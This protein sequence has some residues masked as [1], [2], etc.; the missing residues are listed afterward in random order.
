MTVNLKPYLNYK[1]SGIEHLGKVP[2]H[3]D[4]RTLG[5]IGSFLKGN[6]GN[7]DDEVPYGIPCIR[8]GDLYTTHDYFID[9]SRSCISDGKRAE[10]TA[11]EFGDVLFAGSGETIA[12]IGKSCIAG[13]PLGHSRRSLDRRSR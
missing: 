1:P 10:Y 5:Q 8:Y 13:R 2:A 11:I 3:W 6:G 9:R 4:V 7:K 12:E